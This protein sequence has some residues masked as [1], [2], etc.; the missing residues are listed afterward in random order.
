AMQ[1]I[2]RADFV[3]TEYKDLAYAD[4]PLPIGHNQTISQPYIVGFMTE[5][6]DIKNGHKVLE[7]GSGCGYQTAILCKLAK[8]IYAIDIVEELVEK[9]RKNL[10][11]LDLDNYEFKC[12]DGRQGWQ[13]KAPFDRILVA[14]ASSDYPQELI[15]QLKIGGKMIIPYGH[16][17][18]QNLILVTKTESEIKKEKILSVRFVPLVK[19]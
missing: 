4:R 11:Q 12:A 8:Q 9:A 2:D 19:K 13:D 3:D 7:V 16:G 5:K 14:A 10:E 18:S 17:F 1:A 6:L 15:D